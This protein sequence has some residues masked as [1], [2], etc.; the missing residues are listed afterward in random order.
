MRKQKDGI[1]MSKKD[2]DL[3]AVMP[4]MMRIG[5]RFWPYISKRKLIIG[6]SFLALLVETGFRLLEPWPL[7]FVFDHILVTETTNDSLKVIVGYGLDPMLLL[8]L[9]AFSIVLIAVVGSFAAYLST[10]GMAL[11][12]VQI[13][14]DIRG[15]LF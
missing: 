13:L 6:G 14:T 12:A 2:K 10:F 1:E 8:V 7:K 15:D 3:K 11:A 9:L 5:R 4:E